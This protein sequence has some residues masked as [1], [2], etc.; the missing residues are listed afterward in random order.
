MP[1]LG[2]PLKKLSQSFR[3]FWMSAEKP[4]TSACS[5]YYDKKTFR[6]PSADCYFQWFCIPSADLPPSAC[7][8][9]RGPSADIFKVFANVFLFQLFLRVR[10]HWWKA[11]LTV[12][13][14]TFRKPS[15]DLPRTFRVM[16]WWSSKCASNAGHA[17]TM[18]W[19]NRVHLS[20]ITA[21]LEC[22]QNLPQTF[23]G[24]CTTKTKVKLIVL[25]QKTRF[26]LR[27]MQI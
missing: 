22:H 1:H 25:L 11:K 15:A 13:A 9:F 7:K 24:K 17:C 23:R 10:A 8:T 16:K 21:N 12:C 14:Q 4:S 27:R 20:Q 18:A 5:N 26:R 6:E 2:R 19:T 3:D